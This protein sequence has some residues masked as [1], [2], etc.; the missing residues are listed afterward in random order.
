MSFKHCWRAWVRAC[1]LVC[2]ATAGI[3]VG[4]GN[5]P[6]RVGPGPAPPP[7][8]GFVTAQEL[9]AKLDKK[10]PVTIIDVRSANVY[11]ESD[12]K[13]RGA[14]HVKERRLRSRLSFPPLSNAPRDRE[15]VI[16][17]ACPN[18]EASLRAA[19]I[20]SAAGFSRVR[21]LKGGWRAWSE[22]RGQ[23]ESKPR[24]I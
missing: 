13:I 15:V 9:K 12:G 4:G 2:A 3:A 23:I 7:E 8:V 20:L 22:A 18:D 17:C 6:A 5:P 24:G 10:E 1:C 21:V 19:G 11:S 14:L 16:Y